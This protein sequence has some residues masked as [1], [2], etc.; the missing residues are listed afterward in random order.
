MAN[1]GGRLQAV[2]DPDGAAAVFPDFSSLGH[3]SKVDCIGDDVVRLGYGTTADN[4]HYKVD[5]SV[6]DVQ[7]DQ[8]VLRDRNVRRIKYDALEKVTRRFAQ[9]LLPHCPQPPGE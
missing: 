7:G 3:G 4:K 1:Q 8:L 6:F 9:Q 5:R 2:V